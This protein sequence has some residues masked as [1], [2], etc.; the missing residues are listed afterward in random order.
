M[1]ILAQII[2]LNF[3]HEPFLSAGLT[4]NLPTI[5][6]IDFRLIFLKKLP[7]IDCQMLYFLEEKNSPIVSVKIDDTS[8]TVEPFNPSSVS[9]YLFIL[10]CI[11]H[12][13]HIY[14][15]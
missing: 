4:K 10:F 8:L 5:R 2:F 11:I 6:K 14:T 7:H 3:K 15:I 12:D 1:G 13:D 9:F